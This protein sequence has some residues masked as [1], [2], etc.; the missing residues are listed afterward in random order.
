MIKRNVIVVFA[1]LV[2]SGFFSSTLQAGC[3]FSFD[4]SLPSLPQATNSPA[5]KLR[6]LAEDV[7]TLDKIRAS[8]PTERRLKAEEYFFPKSPPVWEKAVVLI[9][10]ALSA[11]IGFQIAQGFYEQPTSMVAA[12]VLSIPAYYSADLLFQVMHKYLDSYARED[13]WFWG[14]TVR[15]FRI[16]HE[17]PD[18]LTKRDYITNVASFAKLF[19]PFLAITA[20]SDLGPEVK[21]ALLVFLMASANTTE[22]H[23]Q[24]HL[25]KPNFLFSFLQKLN[26][27][28]R[29]SVHLQHHRPPFEGEYSVLNGWSQSLPRHID[30]WKRMD[31][32]F[33]R[34]H[35]R[36][37]HN[38]IQ[39]PRS[40]PESV[41]SEIKKDLTL[42]PAQLWIY[43]RAYPSRMPSELNTLVLEAQASWKAWFVNSRKSFYAEW[44]KKNPEAA[45][46]AEIQERQEYP[47]IFDEK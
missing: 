8:D 42:I 9:N 38:W 4:D 23:R 30:L 22:F 6:P 39:D 13:H 37:P 26:L 5:E 24:A 29:H 40:I 31:L 35:H 44:A 16:H 15:D 12:G 2:M 17:F 47:W 10:W 45:Q 19:A 25:K 3:P 11:T 41:V 34:I 7:E 21:S 46:L 36:M 28:L 20:F 32:I 18:N 33:W 43:T 27:A 1:F 14:D